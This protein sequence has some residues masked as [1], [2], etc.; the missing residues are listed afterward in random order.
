MNWNLSY[1]RLLVNAEKALQGV[2]ARGY[3]CRC[4]SSDKMAD[5]ILLSENEESCNLTSEEM[6]VVE[7]IKMIRKKKKKPSMNNI[8]TETVDLTPENTRNI[9]SNLCER[10]VLQSYE[11]HGTKAYRV[12]DFKTVENKK[13]ANVKESIDFVLEREIRDFKDFKIIEN[14]SN[15]SSDLKEFIAYEVGKLRKNNNE[16]NY[17]IDELDI[18]RKEN[19]F[20]KK[21]IENLKDLKNLKVWSCGLAVKASFS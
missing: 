20:L 2:D 21:E 10:E 7:T 12:S 4:E 16:N 6:K 9:L 13:E 11:R 17:D 14:F 3:L 5:A 1:G 19:S 15:I 18:L 8:I